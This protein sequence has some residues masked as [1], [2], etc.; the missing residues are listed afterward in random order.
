[1]GSALDTPEQEDVGHD[2]DDQVNGGSQKCPAIR[3]T[4]LDHVAGNDRSGDSRDLPEEVD[5]AA[6]L[7][8]VL[9]RSNQ[10][11]QRPRNGC[12]CG[13]PAERDAD[14]EQCQSRSGCVGRAVDAKAEA[15]SAVASRRG[16]QS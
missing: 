6:Y 13:Q 16:G 5:D 7:A 3:V 9:G 11:G 8:N 14:P 12:R 2:A 10:R 4:E 1:M 15:D